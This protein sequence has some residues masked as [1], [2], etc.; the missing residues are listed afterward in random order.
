MGRLKPGTTALGIVPASEFL[1]VLTTIMNR[2][3]MTP[4]GCGLTWA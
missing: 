3:V 4:F 1:S 2:F